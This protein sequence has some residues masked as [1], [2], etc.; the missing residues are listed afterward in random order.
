MII[1][2]LFPI[3]WV[4]FDLQDTDLDSE[5]G[6]TDFIEFGSETLVPDP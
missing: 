2:L 3:L 4:I 5:S 6:S 1:F